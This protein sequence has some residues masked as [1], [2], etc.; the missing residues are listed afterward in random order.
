MSE[1]VDLLGTKPEWWEL[2]LCQETDP[3]SFFPEQGE[4]P[5]DALLVC[6]RCEPWVR[7]E[8]LADALHDEANRPKLFG[9]RGGK[10][11]HEREV[12]LGK[13]KPK[14]AKAEPVGEAA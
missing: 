11:A 6:S 10:T 3:E 4:S 12:L 7:D 8:C 14:A 5:R 9:V 1:V 13:R 2:A